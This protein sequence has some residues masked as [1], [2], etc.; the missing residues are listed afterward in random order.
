[1]HDARDE[2]QQLLV[3]YVKAVGTHQV[4]RN[5]PVVLVQVVDGER[6]I[7]LHDAALDPAAQVVAG[8]RDGVANAD[9]LAPAIQYIRED[10]IELIQTFSWKE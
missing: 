4:K 10:I 3:G 1:M 8:C 9:S 5:E 7:D 2:L 6:G